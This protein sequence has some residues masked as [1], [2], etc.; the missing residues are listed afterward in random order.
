MWNTN[1]A[2]TCAPANMNAEEIA[3]IFQRVIT[4][5]APFNITVT[6]DEAVYN[7]GN[8]AKRMRVVITES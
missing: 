7:S 8:P 3:L 4:D 1:G 2:I 5:Y 6:T